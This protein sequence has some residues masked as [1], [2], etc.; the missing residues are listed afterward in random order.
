MDSYD[1]P[2]IWI[3]WHYDGRRVDGGVGSWLAT[4]PIGG[5]R[6]VY[7]IERSLVLLVAVE[8]SASSSP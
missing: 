5:P 6:A 1:V 7:L 8:D 2:M 3:H 4:R